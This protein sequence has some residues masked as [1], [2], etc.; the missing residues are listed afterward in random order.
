[1]TDR[2]THW[3]SVYETKKPD[4]VSWYQQ[5]LRVSLELIRSTG[6]AKDVALVDVGGGASTLVD[7]LLA[8]EYSNITV[9]DI[10]AQA[11]EYSRRRLGP[12]GKA[13]KWFVGDITAVN[14]S[15][16]GCE[17]WHDRAVFHFLVEERDRKKYCNV[18]QASLRPGGFVV[19]ATFGPNGPAQCSG[20][21]IVRYDPNS[22]LQTLGA[23]FK[24]LSSQVELH[25]TP[26]DRTQEFVYCLLQKV[27]Q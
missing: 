21:N 15:Q 3:E 5:S 6:L 8:L 22:L 7:D 9:L 27:R 20:L 18:L 11:L 2:R 26:S 24:L 10:S 16:I 17:I 19:I 14:P 1:M 4:S 13:V 25:R 12:R 23:S